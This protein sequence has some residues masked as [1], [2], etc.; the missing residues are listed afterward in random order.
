MGFSAYMIC[1]TPRSG[2]TLLCDL[3]TAV[4]AGRPHSFYRRQ[5]ITE[6]AEHFGVPIDSGT[7]NVEFD[8]AY[9]GAAIREGKG[10]TDCFGMRIMAETRPELSVRLD[11][12]FPG[13]ATDP[14]RFEAAFGPLLYI[15]LSRPDKVAQAISRVRAEQTGLWHMN[16]D[17]SERERVAPPQPAT[18]DAERIDRHVRELEAHDA[19]WNQWFDRH[20]IVPVRLTY[21]EVSTEP[22]S[23]VAKILTA[24]GRDP[25]ERVA[26]RTS[27]MASA[28]STAWAERFRT[29]RGLAPA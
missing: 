16:A 17:G 15:H 29:E 23:A 5:S 26:P 1:A 12:L 7:D 24:L 6:W 18:Y 8:R 14:S 13:L 2:S 27:K 22:R 9:L 3:L 20:G 19:D 10:D 25:A 11:R 28:E 4:G 21:D